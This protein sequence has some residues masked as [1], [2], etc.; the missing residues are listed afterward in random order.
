LIIWPASVTVELAAAGAVTAWVLV[1]RRPW[2][3]VAVVFLAALV[4]FVA[5]AVIQNLFFPT[6]AGHR[7]MAAN[8]VGHLP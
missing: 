1:A 4:L 3:R 7:V 2:W 5:G 6:P 8:V